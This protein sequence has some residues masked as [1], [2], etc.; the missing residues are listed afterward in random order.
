MVKQVA[1]RR[2]HL[3]VSVAAKALASRVHNAQARSNGHTVGIHPA[4]KMQCKPKFI[5]Y[6]VIGHSL[7]QPSKTKRRD[8]SKF[9]TLLLD[10][11]IGRDF[12]N[13]ELLVCM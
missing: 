8:Q 3:Q 6:P 1:V 7:P 13:L 11:A 9:P 5:H 2:D 10:L 12:Q 4:L